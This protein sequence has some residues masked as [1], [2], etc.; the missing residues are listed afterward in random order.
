MLVRKLFDK[1][2]INVSDLNNLGGLATGLSIEAF[3]NFDG[4]EIFKLSDTLKNLDFNPVQGRALVDRL[5]FSNR[6]AV[7]FFGQLFS[8]VAYS[9]VLAM[10]D[11][12]LA[13]IENSQGTDG[14]KVKL[15]TTNSQVRCSVSI[16]FNKVS[17]LQLSIH[18][19]SNSLCLTLG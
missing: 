9:K 16:F 4:N 2:P 14:E 7:Q 1:G 17:I 15:V 10:S 18:F 3:Q 11:T 6:K 8:R 12:L 19:F 13:P 5:Q